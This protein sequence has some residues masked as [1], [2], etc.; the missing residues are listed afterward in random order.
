MFLDV[1][2]LLFTGGEVYPVQI[3]S[4]QILSGGGRS[5]ASS[6]PVQGRGRFTYLRYSPA[7]IRTWA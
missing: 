3:V 5:T 7:R 2:V 4:G 1:S 6:S